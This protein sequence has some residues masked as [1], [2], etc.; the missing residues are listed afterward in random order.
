MNSC[1]HEIFNNPQT[2]QGQEELSLSFS[3]FLQV[4]LVTQVGTY[5]QVRA[6]TSA[7][8]LQAHPQ[9]NCSFLPHLTHTQPTPDPHPTPH[10]NRI[11]TSHPH[12]THTRLHLTHISPTP[13]PHPTLYPHFP[14]KP[15]S[16][17]AYAVPPETTQRTRHL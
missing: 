7:S 14:P 6:K 1:L 13:H 15:L 9:P 2:G 5:M 16:Q 11:N 10:P 3:D 12:L 4:G 17:C 8:S